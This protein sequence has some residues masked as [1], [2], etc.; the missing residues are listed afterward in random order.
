MNRL[1]V[2]AHFDAR[3]EVKPYV[4]HHL[5]ALSEVCSAIWFVS[6]AALPKG[7]LSKV[8]PWCERAW[9]RENVGYDFGMWREALDGVDAT[10]WD[11]VVLTNSSVFGPVF[12]LSEAFEKMGQTGYDLWGMTDNPEVRW[13]LQ[14]FFL[15]FRKRLLASPKFRKFWTEATP[16]RDKNDVISKY[17]LG[18]SEYMQRAG[19]EVGALVP[20]SSLP[21]RPLLE[22]LRLPVW[23]NPTILLPLALLERRMPYVKVELLRDNPAQRPLRPVLRAMRRAGYDL[24]LIQIDPRPGAKRRGT[25]LA[26][27][28]GRALPASL[29]ARGRRRR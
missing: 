28:T 8:Q 29:V 22:R 24:R 21:A 1:A 13:H 2:F 10:Q 6:S 20:Y 11:E 18:V 12:P 7:E 3:D 26:R 27:L 5:R 16:L 23:Y 4:I 15:V 25:L 9:T 19:F 14:T 17:E